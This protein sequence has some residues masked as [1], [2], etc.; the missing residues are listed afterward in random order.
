MQ[1]G[2]KINTELTEKISNQAIGSLAG[3]AARLR[4]NPG[5]PAVLPAGQA[6]GLDGRLT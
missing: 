6:A 3:E 2:P 4:P 5:E 1:P